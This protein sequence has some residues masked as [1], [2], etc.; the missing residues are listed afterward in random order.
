MRTPHP[1]SIGRLL[2]AAGLFVACTSADPAGSEVSV[3]TKKTLAQLTDQEASDTCF[4][5]GAYVDK[6]LTSDEK[7]RVGCLASAA[8]GAL[9][10]TDEAAA[11]ASCRASVDACL[12]EGGGFPVAFTG[13]CKT[14]R[15]R[16]KACQK[17]VGEYAGCMEDRVAEYKKS[18]VDPCAELKI[19]VASSTPS[20]PGRCE[21]VKTACP[22][23]LTGGPTP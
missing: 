12:K 2:F 17:T 22:T 1:R 13:T 15:E 16:S 7:K 19:G 6:T 21:A 4:D 5:L 23:L 11:K 18:L 3:D 8:L 14:F 9:G 10:A 20:A